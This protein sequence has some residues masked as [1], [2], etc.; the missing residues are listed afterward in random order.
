MRYHATYITINTWLM[1]SES[2]IV[3]MNT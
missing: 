3:W 2:D 1:K